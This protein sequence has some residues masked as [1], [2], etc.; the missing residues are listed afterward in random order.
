MFY[1]TTVTDSWPEY[2]FGSLLLGNTYKNFFINKSKHYNMYSLS[3]WKKKLIKHGFTI[4][5]SQHYLDNKKI[6]RIFDISHYLSIPSL[7][8]KKVFNKWVLFPGKE[9]AFGKIKQ[10]ILRET[11]ADNYTGPY[12]FIAAKRI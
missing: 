4:I 12:L 6:L 2:L 1:F 3:T 5:E 11:K 10:F 7:F 8:T 9:K